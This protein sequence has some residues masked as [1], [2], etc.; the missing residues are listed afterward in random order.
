MDK[1]LNKG[2]LEKSAS[3]FQSISKANKIV[4]KN[5]SKILWGMNSKVKQRKVSTLIRK[6]LQ[7][8]KS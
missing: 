8:L 2:Q 1:H 7:S 3:L 6:L 5:S 4:V